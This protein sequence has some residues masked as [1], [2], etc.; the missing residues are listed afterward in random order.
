RGWLSA[1]PS[2]NFW[3]PWR[4]ST[5][6]TAAP[7][8]VPRGSP[9]RSGASACNKGDR[10]QK[11]SLVIV[12]HRQPYEE[13]V[14]DGRTIYRENKGPNGIVPALKSFFGRVDRGRGAWVAWKQVGARQKDRF[15]RVVQIEDSFGSYAVS[16]LPLTADQVRSF[17]HVTS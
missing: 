12:Y 1:T 11:S 17:Y 2:R 8:P 13:V 4:A 9:T 10:M 14:E 15:E 3:K 5:G 6:S 16:R 7:S